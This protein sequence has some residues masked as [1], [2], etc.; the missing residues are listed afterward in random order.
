[1]TIQGLTG[2]DVIVGSK[3]GNSV[4]EG[5]SGTDTYNLNSHDA[6]HTIRLHGQTSE[7][8]RDTVLSDSFQGYGNAKAQELKSFDLIEIDAST[9][10]NYTANTAVTQKDVNEVADTTDLTNTVMISATQEALEAKN[11]DNK[12]DGILGFAANTGVLLYSASGN[13]SAD[14]Q[15][16]LSIG[17]AEGVHFQ[18]VQQINVI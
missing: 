5:G 4:L 17:A 9:F 16:L 15:E 7:A 8:S 10:T 18:P 13:F 3:Q 14:A 6:Q 12:G 2:N 1:M 11:F